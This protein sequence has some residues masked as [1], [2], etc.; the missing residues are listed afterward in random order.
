MNNKIKVI[1]SF[2]EKDIYYTERIVEMGNIRSGTELGVINVYDDVLR[3]E[4]L[5]FGGAFTEAAAYNY[6]LMDAKTKDA[7]MK[8]YF[9][10]ESGI[11]YNF[12]RTHINSCD[13][14]LDIYTY[15]KEG[16]TTL[17][18]FDI[19]RER[20]YVIPFLKDAM[21]YCK[22]EIFL[23]A[24]PWSPPAYM[25]DNGSMLEGGKLLDEYKAIWALYYAKYIKAFAE[26][27]IKISAL[28]VQNEPIAVQTWESCGYTPED[29]RSFLADYLLPALDA[30][31]LQDVKIIVWD[32]NKER[33]YDRAKHVLSTPA[34]KDRTMAV[35]HHWYSGN[36][37]D[38]LRL[39]YEE[40]DKP[41]ICTEFCKTISND[42]GGISFAEDYA[43]EISGNLN[44][45][46]IA[47]C[48]WNLMLDEIG[49]P[50]H[51]R[52]KQSE[53]IE[54]ASFDITLGGCYAPIL[55]NTKTGRMDMTP[56]YYYIG[57]FSKFIKRGAHRIGCTKHSEKLS[58][59]AFLNPDG[60]RVVVVL[61]PTD[62]SIPAIIR[63]NDICTELCAKPHSIMT[64]IF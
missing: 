8:A 56:V 28:S 57:H 1:Q 23:F 20:K 33:V 6:S 41:T 32:H 26:E 43:R 22:E 25:K 42:D 31:G 61:N 55:Y 18:T 19:S 63:N 44:N 21:K 10:R 4:I 53:V 29:E 51:N 9:D 40:L 14:S 48:D 24:S 35:G 64:L 17:E 5:G 11:G 15:V 16:D 27:G 59:S 2:P 52:T 50:F 54:G 7:F 37:F 58:V 30:E 36:H 13:F 46:N 62:E 39:V 3:Q 60:E 38:G 34:V 47:I 49:G 45:Y 12:G